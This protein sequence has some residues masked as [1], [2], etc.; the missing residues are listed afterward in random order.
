VIERASIKDVPA[1]YENIECYFELGKMLHRP[2]NNIYDNI[3]KFYVVRDDHGLSKFL[4]SA[5]LEVCWSGDNGHVL[6]EIRSLAIIPEC[7]RTGLGTELVN[8]LCNQAAALKINSVFALTYVG[9][10]FIS[11]GFEQTSIDQIPGSRIWK[12]CIDCD[13]FPPCGPKCQEIPMLK[14]L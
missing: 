13:H 4:G 6:A 9:E 8:H 1:I 7:R 14:R 11:C 5:S 2:I 12:Q 3:Q 10:F